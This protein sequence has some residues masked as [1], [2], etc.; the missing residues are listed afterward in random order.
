MN[1]PEWSAVMARPGETREC[2]DT[3]CARCNQKAEQHVT[4]WSTFRR[5]TTY[6]CPTLD[7][8]VCE[9]CWNKECQRIEEEPT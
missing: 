8:P 6:L 4:G 9:R 5:W 7:V 3:P 1:G 2:T